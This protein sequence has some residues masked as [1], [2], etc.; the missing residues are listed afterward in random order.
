MGKRTRSAGST[1]RGS[2]RTRC[3]LCAAVLGQRGAGQA[4]ASTGEKGRTSGHGMHVQDTVQNAIG[5]TLP[6]VLTMFQ[7]APYCANGCLRTIST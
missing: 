5:M 1:A 3:R 2:G 7:I 6:M 4:Q